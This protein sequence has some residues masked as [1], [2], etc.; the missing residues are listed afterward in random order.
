MERY[1]RQ[2]RLWGPSGQDNLN[3]AR[4]CVLGPATA[5]LQEVSKNLV[6]AGISS[7][8]WLKEKSAVQPGPLFLAKLK[9]DLE[10]LTSKQLEYEEKGLEEILMH[11]HYDWSQFSVIILTCIGK[12]TTLV[13]LNEVRGRI[14]TKFPPVLNTSVSGFYGYMN[15]VLS[16][17][18]FV[19]QSHPDNKKYD[20]R[21]QQPW[22]E[23]IDYVNTFDLS[24]MDVVAFSGIPYI[25]LLIKCI[26]I[27]QKDGSTKEITAGRVRE[28]LDQVCLSVG[29]NALCESNYV[30]ARRYAYLACSQD[31][32]PKEQDDLLRTVETPND[33]HDWHDVY[34]YEVLTLLLVLKNMS[35]GN[36]NSTFQP[37]TSALP[38]MESTTGNYIKLK[39]L[40]EAKAELDKSR[41]Q[42][43][44][45]FSRKTV[46]KDVLN[47]FCSHSGEIKIVLPPKG[48]LLGIFNTSHSLLSALLTVQFQG[49]FIATVALE[50]EFKGLQLDCNY[51]VMAFFG[52]AVAQEA[53][54]LITHHYVPT[55]D[56]FLY[57]GINNSSVMYKI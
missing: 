43:S 1:D 34:N 24:K 27:L 50:D 32:S 47:A 12:Q 22:P 28:A 17:P 13:D 23:L 55:D 8:T 6:L 31:G 18:H 25:I 16:E 57:N 29:E 14:G 19:L 9:R 39:T 42:Q 21:L 20:L 48:D 11:S 10:P 38:D 5:L 30:E 15:L 45:I 56:L 54:K 33:A 36:K 40:Y 52:G 4:V 3:Q 53:I 46:S 51:P 44:L 49:E 26:A 7:L 35:R 41:I 2:V 37:L